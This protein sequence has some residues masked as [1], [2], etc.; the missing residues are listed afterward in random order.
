MELFQPW[1]L[2]VL[3]IISSLLALIYVVPLWV[4]AGKAGL[5]KWATIAAIIP[6]G[7]VVVLYYIAFSDWKHNHP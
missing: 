3:L 1:H 4:I 2:V 6:F 7:A 5:Q